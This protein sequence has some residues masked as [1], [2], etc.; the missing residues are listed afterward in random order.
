MVRLRL[1]WRRRHN[2]RLRL[3]DRS[4][5]WWCWDN[6]SGLK[7]MSRHLLLLLLRRR[8]LGVHE[9]GR[10]RLSCS[11]SLLHGMHGKIDKSVFEWGGR[12]RLGG[13][14]KQFSRKRQERDW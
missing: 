4:V 2:G 14:L 11:F 10:W 13:K 7:L 9:R 3:L 6:R 1:V 8:R 5:W 12:S